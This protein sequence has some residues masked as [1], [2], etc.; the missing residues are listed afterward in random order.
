[1]NILGTKRGKA[2]MND[3][4]IVSARP[5]TVLA[6][7][8]KRKASSGLESAVQNLGSAWLILAPVKAIKLAVVLWVGQAHLPWQSCGIALQ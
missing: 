2:S 5:Y 1:V 8:V 7:C 4:C 6:S 3:P